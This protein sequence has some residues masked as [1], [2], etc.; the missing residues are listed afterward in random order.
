[1]GILDVFTNIVGAITSSP[2]HNAAVGLKK[3]R[4]VSDSISTKWEGYSSMIP[5]NDWRD[6]VLM[7]SHIDEFLNRTLGGDYT[8]DVIL[9]DLQPGSIR[10]YIFQVT[11]NEC[12]H[13]QFGG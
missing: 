3:I 2:E 9:Q 4:K 10:E 1:M 8:R 5:S 7:K 12:R 13:S 11:K 6:Q